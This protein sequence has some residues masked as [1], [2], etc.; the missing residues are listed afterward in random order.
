MASGSAPT[1]SSTRLTTLSSSAAYSRCSLVKSRLPHSSACWAARCK[2]LVVESE[3]NWV[4]STCSACL[5]LA[6]PPPRALPSGSSSKNLPKKSSKRLPPPSGDLPPKDERPAPASAAWISQRCS[7]LWPSPGT[8]RLTVTTAGLIPHMSHILVAIFSC[9]LLPPTS[10]GLWVAHFVARFGRG[11][12]TCST[13]WYRKVSPCTFSILS[14]CEVG[15]L[16]VP[17]CLA[18]FLGCSFV[19]HVPVRFV[20][21]FFEP[22]EPQLFDQDRGHDG[23]RDGQDAAQHAEGRAQNGHD[24]HHGRRVQ[25]CGLLHDQRLH[26]IALELLDGHVGHK[27]PQDGCRTHDEGQQERRDG[28]YDRPDERHERQHPG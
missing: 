21:R 10:R 5:G 8:T 16:C 13:R 28:R 23:R 4:M 22:P 2:R 19:S 12:T 3:K 1:S 25:R 9:L 7:T 20:P 15:S 17:Y 6:I 14:F 27:D 11:R 26:Q 24:R 18:G